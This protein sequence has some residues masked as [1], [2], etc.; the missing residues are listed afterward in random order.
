MHKGNRI[1]HRSM[2]IILIRFMLDSIKDAPCVLYNGQ[3]SAVA[4]ECLTTSPNIPST[5][6]LHA[7]LSKM[8]IP[9]PAP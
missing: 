4:A 5:M 9:L 3:T 1:S 8:L 7:S 2:E 6:Q